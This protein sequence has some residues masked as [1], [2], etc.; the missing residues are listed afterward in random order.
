MEAF[1]RD[2]A[3]AADVVQLVQQTCG[4][5][6]AVRW[7]RA[8]VS[9]FVGCPLFPLLEVWP[10]LVGEVVCPWCRVALSRWPCACGVG[11]EFALCQVADV[12]PAFVVRRGFLPSAC[13]RKL[14]LVFVA[15][16]VQEAVEAAD[17]AAAL[18]H[19]GVGGVY[20]DLCVGRWYVNCV[21]LLY[22]SWYWGW[23]LEFTV[24]LPL[25]FGWGYVVFGLVGPCAEWGAYVSVRRLGLPRAA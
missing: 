9:G 16:C 22:V 21:P 12:G 14:A 19:L 1:G 8:M 4:N 10:F 17:I 23:H 6:V 2:V 5:E 18:D 15:H 13:L 20:L 7:V 24:P 25:G 3:R 11:W